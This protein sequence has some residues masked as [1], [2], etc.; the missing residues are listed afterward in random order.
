[1][2]ISL[3]DL[4]RRAVLSPPRMVV[5]APH[6]I[7]KTSLSAF[8]PNPIFLRFEDGLGLL[9]VATFDL[10]RSYDDLMQAFS[11]LFVGKHDFLTCA[12]DS[13][14][15]LEPIIWDETCRRNNWRSIED[16]GYGK[17]YL[18]AVN[19]WREVMEALNDLRN[20]R[21]MT[22]VMLAHCEVKR[23][24]APDTDPYD[25]YQPKL[26]KLASQLVQE[27]ADAI[28]FMNYRVSLVRTDP[29]DKNSKVRGVGGGQRVL[30]TEERP[31]HL[32]KNRWR[33]PASID[34]PDDP[35]GMWPT[36]AQHIPF[37]TPHAQQKAA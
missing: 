16:T 2:A 10:L 19:V 14:D 12:L 18:A 20:Q 24:E 9:D 33:M 4:Q 29:K 31:A 34:L 11:E 8:A 35:A 27:N 23:F 6:G 5:Y 36:L 32:A 22:I 3:D 21:N 13:L 30:H 17:G 37:F 1:M 7:G 26:H 15:W 25:R 28:F